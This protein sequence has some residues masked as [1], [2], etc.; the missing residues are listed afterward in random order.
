MTFFQIYVILWER[1]HFSRLNIPTVVCCFATSQHKELGSFAALQWIACKCLHMS[2][3]KNNQRSIF[4]KLRPKS[5]F[6]V[7]IVFIFIFVVRII[8]NKISWNWNICSG[9]SRI[10]RREGV[11]LVEGGLDSRGGY[12]RKFCMS[13]RENLDPWGGVRRPRPL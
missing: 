1:M 4:M 3:D 7:H 10:S 5:Y 6:V 13:K 11:D 12:V 9:G 2:S 8:L